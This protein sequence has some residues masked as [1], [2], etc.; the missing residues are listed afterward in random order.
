MKMLI[1]LYALALLILPA[2]LSAQETDIRKT[3]DEFDTSLLEKNGEKALEL[4]SADSKVF[5]SKVMNL[6]NTASR[7]DLIKEPI[8]TVLAVFSVRSAAKG[9]PPTNAAQTLVDMSQMYEEAS[10]MTEIGEITVDGDSAAGQILIN[11]SQ[12]PIDYLFVKEAGGWKVDMVGQLEETEE[13]LLRPMEASGATKEQF[14]DQMVSAMSQV[15]SADVW[16]P[17]KN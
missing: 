9:V 16:K 11:G 13:M 15:Y 6:A 4:L 7:E 12:N 2:A 5:V 10:A 1:H 8:P 3:Y 17:L 14:L